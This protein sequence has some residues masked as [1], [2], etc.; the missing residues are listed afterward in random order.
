[1]YMKTRKKLIIPLL[2]MILLLALSCGAFAADDSSQEIPQAELLELDEAETPV[3]SA[4][5]LAAAPPLLGAS[6][7]VNI[8]FTYAHNSDNNL[9][10]YQKRFSYNGYSSGGYSTNR[11]NIFADWI[12]AYCI[13]PG[14]DLNSGDYLFP[15]DITRWNNLSDQKKEAIKLALLCGYSGNSANL[16]GSADSQHSATQIVIWELVSDARS[17]AP[18]YTLYTP[19]VRDCLLLNGANAEVAAVYNEIV[20]YMQTYYT[21]PS[22]MG[23]NSSSAP[24]FNL[25][26]S[27][28]KYVLSLTDTNNVLSNYSFSS[29]DKNISISTSGNTLSLSSSSPVSS[30]VL[31]TA[32]RVKATSAS[33]SFAVYGSGNKQ[34]IVV[35]VEANS[36]VSGYMKLALGNGSIKIVKTSE[37]G[38]VS[39]IH[40]TIEGQGI[41][42]DVTTDGTGVVTV[43]DLPI[44]DYTVSEVVPTEYAPDEPVQ[45]VNVSAGNTTH[46]NFNNKLKMFRVVLTKKDK[47]TGTLQGD[48]A[49]FEG[50]VYGLYKSN[51]LVKSYTT[52][53][54]GMLYTDYYPCGSGYTI[55]EISPSRGYDVSTVTSI[56]NADAS[57]FTKAYNDVK[58][59]SLEPA[60]K[61]TIKITKY[62]SNSI[63]GKN[64]AENGAV[65]EAYLKTA[66]SYE[67][68]REYERSRFTS[69]KSG[70]AY[71]DPL[72][73][74]IYCV[75]QISGQKG[76]ALDETV[77]EIEINSSSYFKLTLYNEIYKGSLKIVKTDAD[78]SAPLKGAGYRVLDSK[79]AAV[80]EGYTDENGVLQIDN[81]VY[82]E[83]T[84]VEFAAPSGYAIDD[85]PFPFAVTENGQLIEVSLKNVKSAS[86]SI[87][88]IKS[89]NTD[90]PIS[91]VTY[92]LEYGKDGEWLPVSG[93][94]HPDG[95]LTTDESGTVC[96]TELSTDM[97]YR[98]TEIRTADG[99]SLLAEPVFTGTLPISIDDSAITDPVFTIRD[100]V[101]GSLPFTGGHGF[102]LVPI[103]TIALGMSILISTIHFIRR[104]RNN[105][106]V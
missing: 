16:S 95:T 104:K 87:T 8:Q 35:G 99:L 64:T 84:A 78:T 102:V 82:G 93:E 96:F 10:Y 19:E 27:G 37:D 92:L 40:F 72:P 88:V 45:V 57:K 15:N 66:G 25:T 48:G 73:F 106:I 69:N 29:S 70:V 22:F 90:N 98:L 53:A 100:G 79:G 33:S 20:G 81:I 30:S 3:G 38:K 55:K 47:D 101:A 94:A 86:A 56:V 21:L 58:I 76:Y 71:S 28:S 2:A 23:S 62:A 59:T 52:D 97:E 18:P 67:A 65:F 85:T 4:E 43:N 17:S 60:I 26:K 50:A 91:G 7:Y 32:T 68:A 31:I 83:Y 49:S 12:A 5:A 42:K 1:M 39:Y 13:E 11:L 24:E 103:G 61:G 46:V 74:G 105:E 34:M 41:S 89:D 9:I 6:Q 63:T 51:K 36:G 14:R 44:G 75:R 80:A 77:Y 54:F